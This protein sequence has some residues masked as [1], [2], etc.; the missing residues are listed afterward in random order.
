MSSRENILNKLG[1][2]IIPENWL[3]LSFSRGV[4]RNKAI[5][6]SNELKQFAEDYF[7]DKTKTNVEILNEAK[8]LKRTPLEI[9][10]LMKIDIN[11][12]SL[13][14]FNQFIEENVKTEA[15]VSELK[16]SCTSEVFELLELL[17]AGNKNAD[18]KV[19]LKLL[20]IGLNHIK[21][22]YDYYFTDIRIY[23]ENYEDLFNM[24][25]NEYFM[26]DTNIVKSKEN[27][28]ILSEIKKLEENIL[29][30]FKLPYSNQFREILINGF[31]KYTLY[32]SILRQLEQA[33][34]NFTYNQL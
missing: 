32:P 31:K 20:K 10:P 13:F 34:I 22:Y 28:A 19:I 16:I 27:L 24:Y 6:L 26:I 9:F 5:I 15:I 21:K 1:L 11:A 29:A 33:E 30:I 2:P 23:M 4:D 7:L 18:S 17:G 8:E 25:E 14:I 12:Y 3:K